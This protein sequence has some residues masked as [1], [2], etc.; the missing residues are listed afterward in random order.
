MAIWQR[1][2]AYHAFKERKEQHSFKI[3]MQ[4][5]LEVKQQSEVFGVCKSSNIQYVDV[6]GQD[7]LDILYCECIVSIVFLSVLV[8][9]GWDLRELT[10]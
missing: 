7:S 5:S 2:Y 8:P 4:F 10:H 9:A 1:N 6:Y 3:T